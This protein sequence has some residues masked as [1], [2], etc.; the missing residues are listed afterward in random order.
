MR[1]S[2]AA[3]L[4]TGFVNVACG[5]GC[6][7]E[8]HTTLTVRL[9]DE[10]TGDPVCE[11]VILLG[12]PQQGG[13]SFGATIGSDC[14]ARLQLGASTYEIE[15]QNDSYESATTTVILKKEEGGCED[16]IPQDI[17]VKLEPKAVE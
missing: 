6:T 5:E 2:V 16:T 12:Q 17:T 15:V 10:Q 1:F 4:L 14:V 11:G 9:E 13:R 8:A 3:L 7:D